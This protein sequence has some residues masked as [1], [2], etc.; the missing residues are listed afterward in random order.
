MRQNKKKLIT[1]LIVFSFLWGSLSLTAANPQVLIR[2]EFGDITLEIFVDKAPLTA[3]NFLEYVRRGLYRDAVF[4][5]VLTESNQPEDKIKVLLI[6]GGIYNNPQ[7]KT[8]PP[9]AHETTKK[10]GILHKDGVISLPRLKPGTG[11]ADFFICIGEQPELDFGGMRNPD[12]KGF[13]AFGRVIE[14]MEA[15]RRIQKQ[16]TKGQTLEPS[17]KISEFKI[18]K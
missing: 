11:S 2:T 6:Q 5:R 18:I 1:I 3:K 14:G 4:Y 16:P 8:L 15:V 12:G 13:A 17:I 9:I 10:S 7:P